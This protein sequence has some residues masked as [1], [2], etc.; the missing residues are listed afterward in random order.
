[1]KT[2]IEPPKIGETVW[3]CINEHW[4]P[5]YLY[6]EFENARCAHA[7]A[8]VKAEVKRRDFFEKGSKLKPTIV[9]VSHLRGNP[10][11]LHHVYWPSGYGKY[12]FQTKKECLNRC[13]ELADIHDASI[14]GGSN[15]DGPMLRPWRNRD[16]II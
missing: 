16:E 14:W 4:Y 6:P 3:I 8:P 10:N 12:L 9:C 11:N 2:K 7:P 5:K 15:F 1:M 13:E